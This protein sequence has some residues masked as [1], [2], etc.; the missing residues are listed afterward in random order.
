[1]VSVAIVG[2]AAYFV[3]SSVHAPA[4]KPVSAATTT[5]VVGSME[6]FTGPYFQFQ[7]TGKW[8]F[9][10]HDSTNSKYVYQKY[11]RNE[12]EHELDVYVNQVPI[13]LD[14]AVPR[15]LPVRIV[16]RNS[17]DITNVSGPCG[18]LYGPG[19]LHQ[20]KEKVVNGATMLCDPDNPNYDVVLSEIN[21]DYQLSMIRPNGTP[22]QFVII[23]K[24]LGLAPQP[25]SLL[26]IAS[27]FRTL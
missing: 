9:D 11:N 15:V 21:G 14:L 8:S 24:D 18:S 19:E 6:T 12:L 27:S 1:M 26:N 25:D 4:A 13:P 2:A 3:Y 10:K 16:N 17:L 22:I 20:V 7:D 23:Y 5:T